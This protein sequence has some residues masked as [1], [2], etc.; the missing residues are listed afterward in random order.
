MRRPGAGSLPAVAS[1]VPR[2]GRG[3]YHVGGAASQRAPGAV[4]R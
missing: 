4:R 3:P 1:R 2:L